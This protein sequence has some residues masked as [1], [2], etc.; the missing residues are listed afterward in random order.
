MCVFVN[1]LT[2]DSSTSLTD[3]KSNIYLALRPT[4][5]KLDFYRLRILNFSSSKTNRKNFIERYVHS[6]WTSN[7][8]GKP[9]LES[10]VVC[11]VTKYVP[12]EGDRY[13]CPICR[14]ANSNFIAFKNSGWT[15]HDSNKKSKDF[16][17]RFEAYIPVYVVNDPVYSSNNKKLKVICFTNRDEYKQVKKFILDT[18]KRVNVLNGVD[19]VDLC[20]R[21]ARITET[22]NPGQ[23]NERTWSH[24]VIKKL[25]FTDTPYTIPAI[26]QELVDDFP[27]DD[28]YYVTSSP[29]ELQEFYDKYCRVGM[30]DVDTDEEE[31]IIDYS[32][33][34][35]KKQ[36]SSPTRE[37]EPE[38]PEIKDEDVLD[39]EDEEPTPVH[40]KK[41]AKTPAKEEVMPDEDFDVDDEEPEEE[42][43]D[44]DDDEIP[45]VKPKAPAKKAKPAKKQVE[46]VQESMDD[47]EI[48][49]LI[50]QMKM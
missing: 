46:S 41:K 21:Y 37:E 12:W 7:E 18:Q 16:G 15:D 35:S 6:V 5:S 26:T 17:R 27:Y 49:A 8:K 11:P 43:E 23:P 38:V 36:V 22:V 2:T 32:G 10:R 19:A 42:S 40:A 13:D 39:E 9:V 50:E 20:I 25:K 1:K 24:N 28:E 47:D 44:E 14:Y 33:G 48:E 3:K 30:D 31:D 4:E 45:D 29:E 34:K